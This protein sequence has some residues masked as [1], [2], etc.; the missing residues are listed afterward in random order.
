MISCRHQIEETEH[1]KL[2]YCIVHVDTLLKTENKYGIRYMAFADC[3][4][5]ATLRPKYCPG[6][7]QNHSG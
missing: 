1:Y 6:Q 7:S 5:Q 4:L 3:R 2:W